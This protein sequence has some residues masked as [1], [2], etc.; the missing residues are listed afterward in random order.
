MSLNFKRILRQVPVIKRLYS[1]LSTRIFKL[2]K[3]KRFLLE[4]KGVKFN[5]DIN[6]PVDKSII[7]FDYYENDQINTSIKL[8]TKYFG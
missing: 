3:K 7:L 6:E 4:F 2:I 5:L 8:I 1:S